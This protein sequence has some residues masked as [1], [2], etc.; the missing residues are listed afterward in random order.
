MR[1]MIHK[2]SDKN[3]HDH[4]PCTICKVNSKENPKD[5]VFNIILSEYAKIFPNKRPMGSPEKPVYINKH[6]CSKLGLYQNI[7]LERKNTI[8]ILIC[9]TLSPLHQMML[10]PS[11][12][13]IGSVVLEKI[14]KFRQCIFAFS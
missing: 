10:W 13:E 12:V 2:E 14:F 3:L 9:K 5:V 8:E 11:F 4:T 7:D 6:I 1:F